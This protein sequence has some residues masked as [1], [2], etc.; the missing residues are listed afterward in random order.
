MKA[1]VP[2]IHGEWHY[3]HFWR[4]YIVSLTRYFFKLK[5]Y[6]HSTHN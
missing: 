3:C 1:E 2:Q 6:S 4:S 5:V